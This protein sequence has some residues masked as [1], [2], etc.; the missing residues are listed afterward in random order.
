MNCSE[1]HYYSPLYHSG[2]LDESLLGMF[3]Q[4]LAICTTCDHV[5]RTEKATDNALRLACDELVDC[6]E[7]RERVLGKIRE[8]Q[9]PKPGFRFTPAYGFAG[10]AVLVLVMFAAFTSFR[11][12]KQM[13]L[14]IYRDA[15]DDHRAEVAGHMNLK[16][17]QDSSSILAVASSLGVT[18]EITQQI[19]PAGFHLDR[20]RVCR[21]LSHRYVHLVYSDGRREVSYFVRSREGEELTGSPIITVNGKAIYADSVRDLAVAGFQSSSVTVLLVSDEPATQVVETIASAAKRF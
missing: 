7:L 14:T 8:E 10:T 6:S 5:I 11:A 15:A 21:L 4:H 13:P 16:W 19:T 2:E 9:K 17:A 1:V 12:S 18:E 20:A 3:Q